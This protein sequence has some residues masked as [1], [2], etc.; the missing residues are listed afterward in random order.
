MLTIDEGFYHDSSYHILSLDSM[1]DPVPSSSLPQS[2]EVDAL[3]T[4]PCLMVEGGE[5]QQHPHS[6]TQG[7]QDWRPGQT[8]VSSACLLC[9][10]PDTFPVQSAFESQV[11]GVEGWAG[12]E[13]SE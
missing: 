11:L 12:V 4:P 1:P 13:A 7:G 3:T 10:M 6:H 9:L 5:V 8:L 2:H